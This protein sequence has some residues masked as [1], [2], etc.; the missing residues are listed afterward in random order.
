MLT[1]PSD[2]SRTSWVTIRRLFAGFLAV[3]L[4]AIVGC[5]PEDVHRVAA[6]LGVTVS[7]EQA[8]TVADAHNAKPHV[9]LAVA[10]TNPSAITPE[11]A[12]AIA[13]TAMVVEQQRASAAAM[14]AGTTAAQWRALRNCESTNNYRSVSRT[15]KYR[16]AYQMDSDFWGTYGDG[17]AAT[18]DQATPEAQDAAAYKGYRARGWQPWTCRYAVPGA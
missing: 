7:N 4:L 10:Q 13:W 11:Q 8:Q 16:G 9:I 5:T 6:E 17:S 18:A 3:S 2:P 15:G 14:P 12:K 1:R